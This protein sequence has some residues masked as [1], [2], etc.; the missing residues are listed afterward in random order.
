MV[1]IV[2]PIYNNEITSTRCIDSI[3]NQ[4]Y[5]DFELIIINDG[6][7]DNT[8]YVINKYTDK[9]IKIISIDHSGPSYARNIGIR[10]SKGEYIYFI[11]SD[12]WIQQE[13]LEILVSNLTKDIDLVTSSFNKEGKE[14][15]FLTNDTILS[16][17]DTNIYIDSYF[18]YPNKN[19]LFNHCWNK[20]FRSEIIKKNYIQFDINL[21]IFEDSKFVLDYLNYTHN[22]CYLS[23]ITYNYTANKDSFKF[24]GQNKLDLFCYLDLNYINKNINR[25]YIVMTI[26]QLI[27][28]CKYISFKNYNI[29]KQIIN[30]KNIRKYINKHQVLNNESKII[31]FLI[32]YKLIA[33]LYIFCYLKAKKRYG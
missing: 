16:K 18:K 29:I 24:G 15:I 12:D 14:F 13:C 22:I 30:H 6:S 7:T 2:L 32:K 9:R 10:E 33:L 25:F 17:L 19:I 20:L 31:P 5:T 4:T 8:L 28:L 23:T 3:L 26:V 11:D 27:R 1:S 21:R